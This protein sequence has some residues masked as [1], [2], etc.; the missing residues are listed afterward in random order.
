MADNTV[1]A[2]ISIV[3]DILQDSVEPFRYP[4]T[5]LIGSLNDGIGELRRLR[6]D[7]FLTSGLRSPTP[8]LAAGDD[9]PVDIIFR[10]GLIYYTAGHIALRDDSFTED[11]RATSLLNVAKSEWIGVA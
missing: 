9:I 10:S 4:T 11:A 5:G 1:D 6:P 2:V 3:R 7:A 8:T